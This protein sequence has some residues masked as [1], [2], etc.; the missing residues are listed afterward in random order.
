MKE[1]IFG[2]GTVLIGFLV[3]CAFIVADMRGCNKHKEEK[4]C[5]LYAE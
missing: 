2:L 4:E 5:L 1:S 3:M